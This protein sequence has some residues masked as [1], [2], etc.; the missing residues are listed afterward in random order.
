ML[1][2]VLSRRF[3]QGISSGWILLIPLLCLFP[4]VG[5]ASFLDDWVGKATSSSGSTSNAQGRGFA[6]GASFTM[7]V[8]NHTDSFVSGNPPKLRVGC[9]GIDFNLGSLSFLNV[10]M[11]EAKLQRILSQSSFLLFDMALDVLCPKCSQL[12]KAAEALSQKL[13]SMSMNDCNAAKGIATAVGDV[14]TGVAGA[15]FNGGGWAA[16]DSGF[17]QGYSAMTAQLPSV[18]STSDMLNWW[19]KQATGASS[20]GQTGSPTSGCTGI[21]AALFPGDGV[22]ITSLMNVLTGPAGLNMQNGYGAMVAGFVGD[23]LINPDYTSNYIPP[24]AENKKTD[25]AAISSTSNVYTQ[26]PDN[27]TSCI[28]T[29]LSGDT[30]RVYINTMLTDIS[31]HLKNQ[32]VVT[33]TK[34]QTLI[35]NSPTA[36]MYGLKV[37]ISS[38]QEQTMIDSMSELD[39]ELLLGSAL[40]DVMQ[41]AQSV[42][43]LFSGIHQ[44]MNNGGNNC[45]LTIPKQGDFEKNLKKLDENV[46]NV[47][48]DLQFEMDTAIR[49]FKSRFDLAQSLQNI[50]KE[51]KENVAKHFGTSV[52]TRVTRIH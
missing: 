4:R 42:N 19:N 43:K 22:T 7:R 32:Q 17:S 47:Y 28:E 10:G 11:L 34:E 52:S 40:M 3:T 25:L 29:Q 24:C 45:N 8:P 21:Y 31:T 6:S 37:A 51:Y 46:Q 20:N 23:I 13:N 5:H 12:M 48:G 35:L 39:S 36:I 15:M 50:N 2:L 26:D 44:N 16:V 41:M 14:G 1:S 30:F 38:G 27:P 9:A 33:D 49:Q 18:P